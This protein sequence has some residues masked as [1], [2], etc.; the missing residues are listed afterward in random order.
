MFAV[1]PAFVALLALVSLPQQGLHEAASRPAGECP[2]RD[3]Y[4]EEIRRLAAHPA[5][6]R[7]LQH[8]EETDTTT[9]R[10][11][12][13]LSEIGAPPFGEENRAERYRALLAEAGVDSVWIDE[14]GNVI[15]LRKG[16]G[17][18]RT[19]VM[20]GH[21]DTVFPEGT[22]VR[23]RQRGDTLYGP[24]VAD[25]ARGL[26]VV[27]AVLRAMN[28]ARIQ[29]AADVLFVGTVGEE[30][31]GDL[32]GVKH[33][34]RQGGR[35]IDAYI[36]VDGVA[37]PGEEVEAITQGGLG[38]R[39]YRAT[40]RGPGGHSWGAFGTG[41]PIHALGRAIRLL[42]EKAEAFTRW[43][44]PRSSYNVGVIGGGTSVNAIPSEAWMEVDLRSEHP[45]RLAALDSILHA[46]IEQ[47]L[48]EE[49]AAILQGPELSVEVELVGD[50]PSGAT[51]P[52]SPLVRRASAVVR[53]FGLEPVFRT[54]STNANVP[55]SLGIPAIAINGGGVGANAHS[56]AE[57]YLNR[58][59]PAGI[60]RALLLLVAEAGLAG[61]ARSR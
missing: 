27:L 46:V 55:M 10:D 34:F 53:Y 30:G 50:R 26:A 40:F 38:S 51:D 28:A 24:G 22:D 61:A 48:E 1:Y 7:A 2:A 21:L 35:R 25:N 60:Q 11:L 29:T 20:E 49:N 56:P 6:R 44:G 52:A 39:R 59:G 18:G 32:R 33:L 37:G 15:G 43:E 54:S 42:D 16:R 41:N 5:V 9:M 19:V 12:V 13:A 8:I 47:A 14:V 17:G 36:S 23:V 31:L 57:W 58:N 4:C 3:R 45:E